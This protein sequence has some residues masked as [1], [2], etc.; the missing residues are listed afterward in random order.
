[1]STILRLLS[2]FSP[3]G[4]TNFYLELGA[5]CLRLLQ[6]KQIIYILILKHRYNHNFL[7]FNI[8]KVKV[9]NNSIVACVFVA[10]GRCLSSRCLVTMGGGMHRQQGDL[11]SLLFKIYK[12]GK[13]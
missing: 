9:S 11:I 3:T 5:M 2:I 10:A 7:E 8:F 6:Q 4:D 1:M 12:L 13:K